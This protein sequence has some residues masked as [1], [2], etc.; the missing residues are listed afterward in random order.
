MIKIKEEITRDVN[1]NIIN[2]FTTIKVFNI[3]VF[4]KKATAN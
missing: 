1:Y 2:R 4:T 3:L